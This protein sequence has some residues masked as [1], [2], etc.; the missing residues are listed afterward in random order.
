METC[1][2]SNGSSQTFL[3]A[4]NVQESLLGAKTSSASIIDVKREQRR[5]DVVLTRNKERRGGGGGRRL[6][7]R[8]T[9]KGN[10]RTGLTC[11]AAQ[12]ICASTAKL[13]ILHLAPYILTPGLFIGQKNQLW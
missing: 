10:R 12:A 7:V 1:D 2:K 8:D 4:C 13:F 6:K 3:M 11:E 5:W 9:A